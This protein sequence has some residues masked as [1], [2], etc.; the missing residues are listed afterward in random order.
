MR[1]KALQKM[2]MYIKTSG[3]DLSIL[4]DLKKTN[5]ENDNEMIQ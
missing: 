2:N 1:T 5:N 3:S 4:Q